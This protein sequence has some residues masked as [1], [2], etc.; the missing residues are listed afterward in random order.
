MEQ[1]ELTPGQATFVEQFALTWDGSLTG[2]MEGR[3][4]GLLMI[5]DR[6]YL[7]SSE[8]MSMLNASAGAVSMAARRLMVAGFIH[9]HVVPGDRRHHYAVDDDI[10]GG[11][12]ATERVYLAR[13]ST[14]IEAGFVEVEPDSAPRRRMVHAR[15]YL[16]WL[17]EYNKTML[18]DW[19]AYRDSHTEES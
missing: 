12:L 15:N 5:L 13:L 4:V 11:F 10:W 16:T 17:R 8:I 7:A 3:I 18:A 9:R 1:Q 14:L 19:E 6:P 2:R